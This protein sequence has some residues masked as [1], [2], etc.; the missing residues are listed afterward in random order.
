MASE[1]LREACAHVGAAAIQLLLADDQINVVLIRTKE[2]V[3]YDGCS[4]SG[5]AMCAGWHGLPCFC[6]A[7]D[8]ADLFPIQPS[9]FDCPAKFREFGFLIIGREC[10]LVD[11][12]G[13]DGAPAHTCKLGEFLLETTPKLQLSILSLRVSHVDTIGQ[14]GLNVNRLLYLQTP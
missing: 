1:W 14:K 7:T 2:A 4:V 13:V 3:A 10:I 9:I 11:K 5:A 8:D 12:D 6:V